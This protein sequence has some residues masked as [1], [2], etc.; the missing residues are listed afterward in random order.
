MSPRDFEDDLDRQLTERVEELAED[1]FGSPTCRSR[2]ELRFGHAARRAAHGADARALAGLT[3]GSES[4]DS[5][6]HRPTRWAET[7]VASGRGA[8]IRPNE[9]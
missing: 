6:G 3:G 5:R 8:V 9:T 7:L 4:N 1:L 2:T